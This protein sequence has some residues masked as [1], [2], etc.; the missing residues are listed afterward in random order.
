M[1]F[2]LPA[3]TFSETFGHVGFEALWCLGIIIFSFF[4]LLWPRKKRKIIHRINNN[5][6]GKWA[7]A[8]TVCRRVSSYT[9]LGS[10]RRLLSP[11]R[12][13]SKKKKA[14]KMMG[15]VMYPRFRAI[16]FITLTFHHRFSYARCAAT[17]K[18]TRRST[19]NNFMKRNRVQTTMEKR[20]KKLFA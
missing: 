6:G 18:S 15:N 9:H 11:R 7:L 19:K 13:N 3:S 14:D 8:L 4:L 16:I 20:H 17:W 1:N 2:C 5:D 12:R 10:Q